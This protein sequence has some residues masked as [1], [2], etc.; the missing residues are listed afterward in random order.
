MRRCRLPG[1]GLAGQ[2][3]YGAAAAVLP[4]PPGT[5][6]RPGPPAPAPPDAGRSRTAPVTLP[7]PDETVSFAAH[8]KPLFR[9]RD[10][11]SMSVRLRPVVLTT[12]SRRTPPTSSARLRDGTMPC[13]GAWPPEQI[14]VF[15]RW[16]ESGF[17]P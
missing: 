12:T 7:G 11:Q 4:T 2:R 16:T 17:Q 5:G 15:P 8:I 3:R 14:E 6:A 9:E 13:D 10:R 1:V